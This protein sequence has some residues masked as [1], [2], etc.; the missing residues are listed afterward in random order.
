[1]KKAMLMVVFVLFL[2]VILGCDL[3]TD[4]GISLGTGTI[5]DPLVLD[6][7]SSALVTFGAFIGKEKLYIMLDGTKTTSGSYF[8]FTAN[9]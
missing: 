7:N 9:T 2:F 5:D 6:A 3:S 1:M 8:T 4:N